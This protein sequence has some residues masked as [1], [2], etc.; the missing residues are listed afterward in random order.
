MRKSLIA[1]FFIA[2]TGVALKCNSPENNKKGLENNLMETYGLEVSPNNSKTL[3]FAYNYNGDDLAK[4]NQ[5][6]DSTLN[7]SKTQS[8]NSIIVDKSKNKLYLV[9]N[10]GID[11]EYLIY[12]GFNPHDDK[13]EQEDGCTPEGMYFI[14]S[15]KGLGKT[16]YHKAFVIN[17][18]NKLDL[19]MGKTGSLIEIHGLSEI[20]KDERLKFNWTDG[21]IALSNENMEKLFLYLNKGDKITIVKYTDFNLKAGFEK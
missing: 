18:P 2:L 5:W 20:W 8:K 10:G 15:K 13:K 11:S 19:E 9:K 12:L 4:Y 17:Y 6:V 7:E 3:D 1:M 14:E 21:C 16:R